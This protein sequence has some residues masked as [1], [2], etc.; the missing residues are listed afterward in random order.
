MIGSRLYFAFADNMNEDVV[1]K[2]CPGISFEG[3][4]KLPNHKLVFNAL[5]KATIVEQKGR[6]VWGVVWCLSCKDIHHLDGKEEV[7]LG[8]Y[9]KLNKLVLMPD[10]KEVEAF[11]YIT[12]HST[13][14]I[15]NKELLDFILEQAL[16]WMLPR[17]YIEYLQSL[18]PE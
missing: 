17:D 6:A 11:L 8:T 14:S 2:I 18:Y 4:A 13:N 12:P 10:E 9:Q 1:R 16:Y 5:G 15:A 7:D 3:I